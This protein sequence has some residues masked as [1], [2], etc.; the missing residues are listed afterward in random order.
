MANAKRQVG[1]GMDLQ[2]GDDDAEQAW[3]QC[4]RCDK[5]RRIPASCAEKLSDDTPW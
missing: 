2:D 3:V 4:D 1:M 5:W